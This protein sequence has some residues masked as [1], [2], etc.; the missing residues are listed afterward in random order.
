MKVKSI[1][2]NFILNIIRL[3]LGTFFILLTLPYITR[4][5]GSENLGKV[6]YGI[7]IV[8]YFVLFTGL[9]IPSYGVREIAKVRENIK[10]RSLVV[11]ELLSILG[12]TTTIGY[13]IFFIF[14]LKLNFY[15]QEKLLMLI[16][17]TNIIFTNIGIEWFYQGIE[18]QIYITTRYIIIRLLILIALFLFIKNSED[19]IIYGGLLV[20][21]TSGSNI[22][23]LINLRKY[24]SFQ[25][26]SLKDLNLKRHIKPIITIFSASL[27]VSIYIQL[28]SVM[29][30]SLSGTEYVGYYSVANK[31]IRLVLIL[32]TA[33]GTV[34]MPRLS[35]CLKNG[36]KIGFISYANI[37][38]KYIL[39][40]SI[41][42]V[43]G[44]LLLSKEIIYI[45]AGEKFVSSILT[46]QI[47][48][49]IIFIVG[50]AYFIGF[51]ILYPY[52]LERYYTYS[53]T[54]AAIINFIFNYIYIPKYHQNGAAMGTVLAELI[55]V[56]MMLIFANNILKEIE[57][58]N[59]NNLKYFV[60]SFTMGIIIIGIKKL[61]MRDI[62][63]LISGI[64]LGGITYIIILILLKEKFTLE[65]LNKIKIR[66]F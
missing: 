15:S 37:S 44:I 54:I 56:I 2:L 17:G 38:L 41:P 18:D 26:I 3:F 47:I 53:V 39:F 57:F 10:E 8:G 58:Y 42:S 51:Q 62:E 1:K 22:L 29:I 9:G 7:S 36:D 25:N 55:G 46:I 30:G 13:I 5:L 45:M 65:I 43:V 33:L 21:M 14:I 61:D 34:M 35:N 20:I 27:A 23:N 63:T 32:V 52:G 12:I 28:D 60:S 24:I 64:I 48:T 4:I 11:L 66:F 40:I 16:L 49:P 31:L 59:K 50:I 6:E 19:Y